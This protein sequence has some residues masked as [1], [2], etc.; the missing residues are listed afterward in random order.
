MFLVLT[1]LDPGEKDVSA[2]GSFV[3]FKKVKSFFR[4]LLNLRQ[5][6]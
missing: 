4:T 5:Q 3:I 1:L 2:I 6:S